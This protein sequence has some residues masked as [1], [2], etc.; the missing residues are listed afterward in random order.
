MAR[1]E[2]ARG[3]PGLGRWMRLALRLAALGTGHTHPNPR[4]GAVA[5]R[6]GRVAGLGAHLFVGGSHAERLMLLDRDPDAMEGSDL[7]LT[8]E[9]CVHRGRTPPCAPQVASAGF[10][11]AWVALADPNPRVAGQGIAALREA[12]VELGVA[13]RQWSWEAAL[14]NAPF[15]AYHAW[16]R[17]WVTLKAA[18]SLD[19]RVAADDGSSQWI[20][21][22]ASRRRVHRWRGA[23]DAILVG[24][25]TLERDRCRLTSRP[26]SHSSRLRDRLA[27]ELESRPRLAAERTWILEKTGRHQP[28]R[29]VVDSEA[30]CA[31]DDEL[32]AHLRASGHGGGPW[33]I[34]CTQAAAGPA[35]AP[36]EAAGVRIWPLEAEAAT[37]RVSLPVLLRA[38]AEQGLM[39]VLV[40]GGGELASSLIRQG[41]VDRYRL[42]VAPLLLG[43]RKTWTRDVGASSIEDGR[44]LVGLRA[45]RSGPDLLL[46]AFSPEGERMLRAQVERTRRALEH[47]HGHH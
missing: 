39:D 11:R 12:G 17:A 21:A 44:R 34:A 25:G 30:S 42:F 20:S 24:R 47:V 13:P 6:D 35:R 45:R 32:L 36:L 2:D 16:T 10:R 46:E 9:P 26:G 8:L 31:R 28:A 40:E 19:G 43:G 29:I 14:A 23:C 7:F 27:G 22:P 15:L 4:V 18:L 5:V 37:G 1:Y 3:E 33:I 41:L 38:C